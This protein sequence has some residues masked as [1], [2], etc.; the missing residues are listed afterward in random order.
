MDKN[1]PRLILTLKAANPTAEIAWNQLENR[2]RCSLVSDFDI[3]AVEIPSR[4]TTPAPV[5]RGSLQLTFDKQPKNIEKG[6]VFGSDPR[7]CDVLL[8]AWAS[9]F[10]RQHFQITFNARGE[11]ILVDTSRLETWI[12]Y[13]GEEPQGRNH[14]TWILFHRYENIK[15]TLNK[16][17]NIEL[18]FEVE[19][20]KNCESCP[21]Q[22]E[23]YRD[24][25]LE[26]RR[27][28][29]PSLSRLGIESQQSEY[30]PIYLPEEELGSGSF[31]TVY[32]A[33]NV[34]TGDEYAAKKFHGGN[35]KQEVE[36]L[37]KISHVAKKY[38]AEF[39]YFSEQEPLLVME[40]LPL[41]NLVCQDYITEEDN[42]Q[43]LCQGLQ[44]L[45]Y[46]HSQSP[47]LAHRDIKPDNILVRSRIPFVVKLVDFG[48][49]KNDSTFKTFCGTNEYAAPEIWEHCHYT[50]M[51]DIW[52]LG[53]VVLQYGYGLPRP[54]RKRKGM[55]WCRDIVKASED[56]EG[57]GDA[58][59]D[60]ISTKMLRMDYRDRQS[61]SDC[62]G[63]VYRLGFHEIQTV[64]VGCTTPT[65]NTTGRDGVT[66]IKSVITQLHQNAQ[67][68]RDVSSG[69]Y[70]GGSASEMTE[71]APSKR[72]LRERVHF[73]NHASPQSLD[74][75]PQGPSQI[76]NYP[77]E[78]AATLTR[79]KRRRPH[80]DL[81]PTVSA[82]GRG[83]SKRLRAFDL[84]E[85]GEQRPRTSNPKPGPKQLESSINS[86]HEGTLVTDI[87]TLNQ[88]IEPTLQAAPETIR[89]RT[90]PPSGGSPAKASEVSRR[91]IKKPSTKRN[92][93]DQ[94]RATLT[95]DE[96]EGKGQVTDFD[97]RHVQIMIE[98][99]IV[100]MRKED[101]FLNATQILAL[102]KKDSSENERLLQ[103]MGQSIKV[104]VLPPI[105]GLAYSC[106]WVNFEHGQ[107]LCKHYGLE[108][109][110]QPLIDHGLHYKA[111]EHADDHPV[112]QPRFFTI[113]VLPQPVTVRRSDFKIR[114]NDICRASDRLPM[115][116]IP[117][118]KRA[119]A[120]NV[121]IVK[122]SKYS[123]TYVNFWD[124]VGLCQRYSLT[125]LETE[126]LTWRS[127][128]PQEP[129]LSEFIK[130]TELASPVIVRR[131]NLRINATHIFKLTGHSKDRLRRLRDSIDSKTY[132]I[133]SATRR[134][135]AGTYVSFS[136]GIEL[137]REY[138]LPEL[139]KRLYSLKQTSEEPIIAEPSH[140]RSRS[141]TPGQLPESIGSERIFS[142]NE[143]AQ[144]MGMSFRDYPLALSGGP[145]IDEPTQAGDAHGM[146]SSSDEVDSEE[147]ITLREA[148]SIQRKSQSVLSTLCEKGAA[149]SHQSLLESANLSSHS[150]KSPQ[151][152]V[153]DSQ[154]KL[155]MLTEVKPDLRPPT[156]ETVS[157]YGSFSSLFAPL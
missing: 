3:G 53:V 97:A 150:A 65:R 93:Q 46:L 29:T 8:G 107:I 84:G 25:Y 79:S 61:A 21:A 17:K 51:V 26:V 19:W 48:L 130:I 74:S 58:L 50:T 55:L 100:L 43:V 98:D 83:Q 73:H 14:F 33:V 118:I 39:E 59:I 108:Q 146:D 5:Q 63:E 62:L 110:L 56:I 7:T 87:V 85:T 133:L 155:S 68:D 145:I 157:P 116:E 64:E 28:A 113:D 105:G 139:E 149:S 23:A 75:H 86:N 128:V 123:G 82:V 70:D 16:D 72:D 32:K 1:D 153:W 114:A 99:K 6:F 112:R 152:E 115:V 42:L 129:E 124:G 36:I 60:L 34:S 132:D 154:P 135:F 24:A 95:R 27:K 121:E 127:V 9:G 10:T 38:I 89:K 78:N 35:W 106:A 66:R 88:D 156:S 109:E 122:D 47:P 131:S 102:T 144:S 31:G 143:A 126:L 125:P 148:A 90:R 142:Q 151:Y 44:A 54:S 69:S 147:N 76:K 138:G 137:C 104:E 117:K 96:N 52:S 15:V 49:A 94:V 136:I 20:P 141:Q 2:D 101:C 111:M 13:D 91:E 71:V 4:D 134:E 67:S 140:T 30:S 81:S 12:S 40:Y 120:G 57:E 11:V 18:V 80:M 92:I 119:L 41:G 77:T 22:Y 103:R 37:R 45:E